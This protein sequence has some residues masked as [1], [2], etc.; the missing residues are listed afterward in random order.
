MKRLE[1]GPLENEGTFVTD[2]KEMAEFL[3][4]PKT[5]EIITYFDHRGRAGSN[6][7]QRLLSNN[8]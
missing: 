4:E 1:I 5:E 2:S 7:I 3:K 6:E 8:Q